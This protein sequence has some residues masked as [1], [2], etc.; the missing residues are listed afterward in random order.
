MQTKTVINLYPTGI[1]EFWQ[2]APN[3]LPTFQH[4]TLVWT[5]WKWYDGT[6]SWHNRTTHDLIHDLRAQISRCKNLKVVMLSVQTPPNWWYENT[7]LEMM[8]TLRMLIGDRRGLKMLII[9]VQAWD[10]RRAHISRIE[11]LER[12]E[13]NWSSKCSPTDESYGRGRDGDVVYTVY[14]TGGELRGAWGWAEEEEELQG[15][16][17]LGE[18]YRSQ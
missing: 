9:R 14:W 12:G 8:Q 13:Y 10:S 7:F 2:L 1:Q 15:E 3:T 16:R 4:L 11:E 5:A 17:A 6:G 18:V